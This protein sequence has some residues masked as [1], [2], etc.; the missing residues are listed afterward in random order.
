MQTSTNSPDVGVELKSGMTSQKSLSQVIGVE[1]VEIE[2]GLW[3]AVGI[4][5]GVASSLCKVAI[6]ARGRCRRGGMKTVISNHTGSFGGIE[7]TIC[8]PTHTLQ[9]GQAQDV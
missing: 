3:V 6:A 4:V 9:R 1:Y 7:Y 8:Q 2:T 5:Q